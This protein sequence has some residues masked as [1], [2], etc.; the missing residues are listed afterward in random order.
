MTSKEGVP[1][2]FPRMS[3]IRREDPMYPGNG[4]DEEEQCCSCGEIVSLTDDE[5]VPGCV[6]RAFE[7]DGR[8]R[9][10]HVVCHECCQIQYPDAGLVCPCAHF[11]E[12]GLVLVELE[13]GERLGSRERETVPLMPVDP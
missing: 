11:E 13:D 12:Q 1:P 2:M 4:G 10:F 6:C 5:F 8:T 7:T 9:C 3:P